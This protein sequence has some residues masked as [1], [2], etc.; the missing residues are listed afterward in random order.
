[1]QPFVKAISYDINSFRELNEILSI[2]N[3]MTRSEQDKYKMEPTMSN[4]YWLLK[5]SKYESKVATCFA[6]SISFLLDCLTSS[7]YAIHTFSN[8]R[9]I[10]IIMLHLIRLYNIKWHEFQCQQL[11]VRILDYIFCWLW[12]QNFLFKAE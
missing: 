11:L 2:R 7:Y 3:I 9:I 12:N 8:Y 4:H 5:H 6:S 1:M 10:H